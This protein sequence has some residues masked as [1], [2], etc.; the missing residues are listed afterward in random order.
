MSSAVLSLMKSSYKFKVTGLSKKIQKTF[1]YSSFAHKPVQHEVHRL[2]KRCNIRNTSIP[3]VLSQP[4]YSTASAPELTPPQKLKKA[5]K[6]YG[7][8]LIAFHVGI[9]LV[10]LGTVYFL[11]SNGVDMQQWIGLL[12]MSNA[13]ENSKIVA[14][15]SEFIIAYAIHKSLAPVRI[16]ITLVSVPLIVRYLRVKGIMK[17]KK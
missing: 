10:S 16:S 17:V 7:S 8:V 5:A 15:A 11:I 4:C 13:D 6:E 2:F 12:G 1:Q 3:L 9:S 14:G